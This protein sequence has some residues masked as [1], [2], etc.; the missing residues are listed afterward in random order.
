MKYT[1]NNYVNMFLLYLHVL[2]DTDDLD[3]KEL[4]VIKLGL[5]LESS[6]KMPIAEAMKPKTTEYL[7]TIK[8]KR[9]RTQFMEF[10]GDDMKVFVT[11]Q[12]LS[13]YFQEVSWLKG[14]HIFFYLPNQKLNRLLKKTAKQPN[15]KYYLKVM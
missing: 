14:N 2:S 10:I 6:T 8:S 9:K 11:C 4:H 3:D 7:E 13:K 12:S 15:A 1:I 5:F